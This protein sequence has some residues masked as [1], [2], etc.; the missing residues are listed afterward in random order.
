MIWWQGIFS[1][2]QEVAQKAK[3]CKLVLRVKRLQIGQQK[4]KAKSYFGNLYI[5]KI[6][7]FFDEK[8]FFYIQK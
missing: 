1:P 2:Q 8:L 6:I 4:R 5:L 7:I 3:L